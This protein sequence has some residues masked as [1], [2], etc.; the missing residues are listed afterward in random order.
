MASQRAER[1]GRQILQE[2][3]KIVESE[4]RDPR[5]NLVTFTDAKMTPDLR[6]ARVYFSSLDGVEARDEA[7]TA[8]GK[9]SGFIRREL[10]R[11]LKLRHV[12]ELRFSPDD[13]LDLADRI[14]QLVGQPASRADPPADCDDEE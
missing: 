7:A 13:S 14:G 9:A 3:S 10:A 2:V 6:Q 11:R 5:L 1:V 4:V 8:L 12:P